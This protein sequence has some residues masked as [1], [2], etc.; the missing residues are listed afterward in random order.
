MSIKLPVFC[1]TFIFVL[2][3]AVFGQS[4]GLLLD[5]SDIRETPAEYNGVAGYNIFIR[6]KQGMESV[7]LTEPA[8]L[9]AL[10]APEWNPINGNE[11]RNLSGVELADVN[12]RYSIVSSTP[13]FDSQFGRAFQLFLPIRVVYGNPSSSAGIVFS[14]MR[15]GSRI[16]IRT[17]DRKYADPNR[18]KFQNNQYTLEPM[19][20]YPV[21][22][23]SSPQTVSELPHN[24]PI[25]Y[26]RPYLE[27]IL[28]NKR[29]LSGMND[30]E[31][32]E[33]LQKA[34]QD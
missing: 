5:P 10:R 24:D 6:Q 17:F 19:P 27:Q 28:I 21:P 7:M 34:F 8:G 33:R 9:Y 4:R 25:V 3:Q 22:L 14:D 13:I 31:L 16:N 26:I 18:S 1:L 11:K 2:P 23:P 12:S 20:S 29:I 30:R 15:G 32:Y